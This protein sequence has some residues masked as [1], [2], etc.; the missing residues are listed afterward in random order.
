M[1][2]GCGGP[3]RGESEPQ[4]EPVLATNPQVTLDDGADLAAALIDADG[5]I[6]GTEETTSGL[7]GLRALERAGRLKFPI[8]AVN[9]AASERAFNDR[10]G[11]GQSAL[12][13]IL[14]ATNLLL[15]GQSLEIGRAHV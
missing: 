9:E 11:T 8:L 5:I 10:F 1:A 4:L 2:H 15:A 14:R 6:G 7:V 12:D 13:G 3:R